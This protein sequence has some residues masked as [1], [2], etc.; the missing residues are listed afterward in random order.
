[1]TVIKEDGEE[2]TAMVIDT[3]MLENHVGNSAA[4]MSIVYS[5]S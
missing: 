5:V 4:G 2:E 3:A 1:V